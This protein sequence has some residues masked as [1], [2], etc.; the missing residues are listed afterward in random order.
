MRFIFKSSLEDMF[1]LILEREEERKERSACE[2][3]YENETPMWERNID[4]LPPVHSPRQG[5]EPA[6]FLVYGTMLRPT[7]PPSQGN[8]QC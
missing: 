2:Y 1:L 5:I 4:G 3:R 7:E 6:A 8:T